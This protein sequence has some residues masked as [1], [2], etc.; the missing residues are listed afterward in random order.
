MVRLTSFW[1]G[2]F[3]I[4]Q[5]YWN[6]SACA[7]RNS[8]LGQKKSSFLRISWSSLWSKRKTLLTVSPLKQLVWENLPYAY[9]LNVRKWA[10]LSAASSIPLHLTWTGIKRVQRTIEWAAAGQFL[11]LWVAPSVTAITRTSVW[12]RGVSIYSAVARV[13]VLVRA[14]VSEEIMR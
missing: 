1:P 4:C 12:Q 14:R 5:G 11:K 13:S 9:G 8:G 7:E 3:I 10:S 2:F 6:L